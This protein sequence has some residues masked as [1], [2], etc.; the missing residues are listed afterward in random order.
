MVYSGIGAIHMVVG[1]DKGKFSK[2][3]LQK[4]KNRVSYSGILQNAN[5]TGRCR[6]QTQR[7]PEHGEIPDGRSEQRSPV[8][9]P[10]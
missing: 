7:E 8:Q 5:E 1:D 6:F 4:M 10:C 2:N 3:P 9:R